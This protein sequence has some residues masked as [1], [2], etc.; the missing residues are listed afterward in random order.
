[1]KEKSEIR[2]TVRLTVAQNEKVKKLLS[3]KKAL[4]DKTNFSKL[5]RQLI[6]QEIDR[7]EKQI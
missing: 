3:L 7:I 4:G 1:M 6:Q 2:R 5:S